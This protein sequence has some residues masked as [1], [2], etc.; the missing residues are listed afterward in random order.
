MWISNQI[1][2]EGLINEY[3]PGQIVMLNKRKGFAIMAKDFPILI[4]QGQ[5]EGKNKTDGYT[6]SVQSDL[7]INNIMGN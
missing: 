3:I 6:L 7:S 4:K 1:I 2:D 5:L